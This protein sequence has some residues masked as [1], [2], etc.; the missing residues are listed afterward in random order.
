MDD[1]E[2]K[3]CPFKAA[4]QLQ[5]DRYC[6]TECAWYDKDTGICAVLRLAKVDVHYHK[7]TATLCR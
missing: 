6:D 5:S 4:E 1:N 2:K 3:V 7:Q